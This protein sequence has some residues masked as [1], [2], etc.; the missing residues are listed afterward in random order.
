MVVITDDMKRCPKCGEV[1]ALSEFQKNRTRKDGLQ[2]WCKTCINPVHNVW[3]EA[4]IEKQRKLEQRYYRCV[5]NPSCPAV[6]GLG[7]KFVVFTCPICGVEFRKRKAG[8]D[9]EYEHRG[10]TVFYCSRECFWE[11]KRKTETHD[12]KEIID[13]IK[14]EN[15]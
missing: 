8:V 10:Q 5:K 15:K 1:K 12:Y 4:N 13:K 3:Y 9:Y 11:S 14:K 7:A 2:V 6:G